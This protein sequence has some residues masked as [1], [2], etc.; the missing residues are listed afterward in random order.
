MAWR[1][2]E[3][4]DE[5]LGAAA[6]HLRAEPVLHTVPLTVLE[7]LRQRGLSAFGDS[8]PIF[9]WHEPDG[10]AVDGAFFRTP[11]LTGS[12]PSRSR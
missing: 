8:P 9:G 1:L 11:P 6:E 3:S 12:R 2:T 7:A 4:L 10:G 5:F